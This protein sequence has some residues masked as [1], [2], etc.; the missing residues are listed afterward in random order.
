MRNSITGLEIVER[1]D[2]G[3]ERS[4]I[5]GTLIKKRGSIFDTPVK[6]AAEQLW[7]SLMKQLFGDSGGIE[8]TGTVNWNCYVNF[9]KADDSGDE[10]IVSGIVYEPNTEDSQGDEANA[11]EIRK[12][13]FQFME[14]SIGFKVMH[15]GKAVKM[16]VLENYIA[17]QDLEINGVAV[18]KGSWVLTTRI[19]DAGI[20]KQIKAGKL[21]GYSMAGTARTDAA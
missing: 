16:Q 21:T 20:W 18:K 4:C 7:P 14:D 5:T 9:I 17:P 13:C 3:L 2:D 11:E 19:H 10:H 8:K 6:K 12:A 1:A 15:K